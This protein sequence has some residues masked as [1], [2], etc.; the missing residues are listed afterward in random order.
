[1]D[2][3]Q[4]R[5]YSSKFAVNVLDLS[6]IEL[7]TQEDKKWNLDFWARLKIIYKRQGGDSMSRTLCYVIIGYLSGSILYA[8][9]FEKL[10]HKEN[11][12]EGSK[13]RNPGTANAFMRGGFWC[14]VLTLCCDM[15]KGFI[16]VF[17]YHQGEMS[18][19]GLALILAAPAI[20][21]IFPLFHK[22]RGGKGIA[23]TFG[24]LLGLFP[25]MTPVLVLAVCFIF[26]SL[27]LRITPH[28]YRTI[29]SYGVS[30]IMLCL[31]QEAFSVKLGFLLITIAV[32]IRFVLSKEEKDKIRVSLLWKR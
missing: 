21:H 19:L 12:I 3:V 31:M 26:F 8:R 17:F 6:H 15:G 1:M 29:G 9:V 28:F 32:G 7:A 20:G 2:V 18:Q 16:P 4:H 23:T 13:D 24:S 14:G 27:I 11:M 10:F 22:G 30:F 5:I 25:V